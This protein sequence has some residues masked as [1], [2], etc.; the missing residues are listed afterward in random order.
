L[1][2]DAPGEWQQAD[3]RAMRVVTFNAGSSECYISLLGGMAGGLEANIN[4]WSGQMGAEPLT[5]EQI[6]GLEQIEVLGAP[7]GLV[8]IEGDYQGMGGDK[9]SGYR[10]LGVVRAGE[11]QSL[12]V[13]MI[14][15]KD[16]MAAQVEPF[17]AFVRSLR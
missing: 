2:W 10:L 16:E 13:K 11:D 17:K 12:F 15:P 4:R 8:D 3:A 7:C 5:P 14:G 1:K 6:A 9:Q